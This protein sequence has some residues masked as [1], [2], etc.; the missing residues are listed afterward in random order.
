MAREDSRFIRIPKSKVI[1]MREAK[2]AQYSLS[3]IALAFHVGKSTA[4]LYCR[5]LFQHPS[6]RYDTEEEA[7]EVI[8][9]RGIGKDH[10]IYRNCVDCGTRIGNEHIRCLKCNL[11]YQ[12]NTGER[13]MFIESGKL[14]QFPNQVGVPYLT[15]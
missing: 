12:E 10:R 11:E 2:K 4:S 6:R 7:R 8:R 13:D 3:E 14:S 15:T 1:L 9:L 5:D